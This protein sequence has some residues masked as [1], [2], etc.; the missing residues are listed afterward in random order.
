MSIPYPAAFWPNPEE[1]LKH[2]VGP[3]VN[4]INKGDVPPVDDGSW[5]MMMITEEGK[6]PVNRS[7]P[8][9]L[10]HVAKLDY[11]TQTMKGFI[12]ILGSIG[13]S[14][15][16]I[17]LE[18]VAIP[19]DK[20]FIVC[21]GYLSDRLDAAMKRAAKH[22]LEIIDISNFFGAK[23]LYKEINNNVSYQNMSDPIYK[24]TKE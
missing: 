9:D 11:S 18:P 20:E 7:F 12:N 5:I 4:I 8:K 21:K 6:F 23:K 3:K 13:I 1:F 19:K 17:D 10:M 22:G 14:H 15:L 16:K 24:F 2:H